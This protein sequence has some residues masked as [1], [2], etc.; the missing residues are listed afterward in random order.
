M[1]A[2][3]VDD[4]V[5]SDLADP[6]IVV[7]TAAQASLVVAVGEGL[8]RVLHWGARIPTHS[9]ALSD[10][11]GS[12]LRS[13]G[14]GQFAADGL[15]DSKR[16]P[17]VVPEASSGWM[18]TPG[19]E[20]H[21]SGSRFSSKFTLAQWSRTGDQDG[22]QCLTTISEDRESALRLHTTFEL[23]T[24]GVLRVRAVVENLGSDTY[25]VN[26]LRVAL[27][28]P[29]EATEVLDFVGRHLRERTPQR[30]P[31]PIG[32]HLREGRRGRTGSDAAFVLAAGV[33]GFGFRTGEL[34]AVHTAW[35][36][37]HATY[38]EQVLTGVKVIGGGEVLLPGEVLLQQGQS[39]EAPWLYAVYARGLD[40][41]SEAFHGLLRGSVSHPQASRPVVL[42]TWEAVYF[43]HRL[44]SLVELAELG[45]KVGAE[46]FVLD[47]GWFLGR[48]DDSAGLGDWV[49]D[50]TTWPQ[51]LSRLVDHVRQR[52]MDFGLWFE[53][54][55]VSEDSQVARDHPNWILAPG[56][57]LPLSGRQQHVLNLTI[58]A[59]YAHVLEQMSAIID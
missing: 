40:E 58:P 10:A 41:L 23:T 43:D 22:R 47:D 16:I 34:W 20:G 44:E 39:Y 52:G 19:L 30:V 57:R 50:P 45:A 12:F 53:P 13:L 49:V 25:S 1:Q 38:A 32:T 5:S 46:R 33:A 55:M 6:P 29:V 14:C 59:A 56:R 21:R 24:Q 9:E 4:R 8:P 48:H 18:G 15:T 51:G 36:G 42:N 26:S 28:V 35:S 54:E 11:D 17:A 31:F 27:P 3:K 7:L 37:N 2:G